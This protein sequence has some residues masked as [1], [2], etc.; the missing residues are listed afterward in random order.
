VEKFSVNI[1][2]AGN[3]DNVLMRVA[4]LHHTLNVA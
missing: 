4:L 1:T 2:I 3:R